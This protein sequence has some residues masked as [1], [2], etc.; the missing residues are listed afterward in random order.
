MKRKEVHVFLF[1]IYDFQEKETRIEKEAIYYILDPYYY[2]QNEKFDIRMILEKNSVLYTGPTIS[3]S[4]LTADKAYCK[5]INTSTFVKNINGKKC[6]NAIEIL[7][8]CESVDKDFFIVKPN[9]K[10]GGEDVFFVK[11]TQL[12]EKKLKDLF[13]RHKEI[14]IEDY[15]K[16]T[17]ISF[18][19]LKYKN[20]FINFPIVGISLHDSVV[21]DSRVKQTLAFTQIT[22]YKISTEDERE[23]ILFSHGFYEKINFRGVLRI[24]YII[25]IDGYYFLEANGFPNFDEKNGITLVSAKNIG[26]DI[27]DIILMQIED[28]LS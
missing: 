18:T 16:G 1:D 17:E 15:I 3:S 27:A 24:D 8:F 14:L 12:D 21:F 28:C 19:L 25:G 11:K 6:T 5:K 22:P 10:G 7:E 26:L 9:D 13:N 4:K 2:I 23:I 20:G